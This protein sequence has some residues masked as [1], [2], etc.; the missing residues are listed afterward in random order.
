MSKLSTVV[1]F[2][3]QIE[4]M[5]TFY[6]DQL[7]FPVRN[8]TPDWTEFDTEGATLALHRMP[9]PERRGVEFRLLVPD[10]EERMRE[11]SE[12]GVRFAGIELDPPRGVVGGMESHDVPVERLGAGEIAAVDDRGRE[13]RSTPA[14]SRAVLV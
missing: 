12:R 14:R 7:G 10:V 8:D 2:T 9:D 5:K 13:S 1:L 11:R 6:G 3:P 4:R